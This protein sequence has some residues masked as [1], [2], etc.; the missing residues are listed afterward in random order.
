MGISPL[1]LLLLIR[2]QTPEP[3]KS[4]RL[5]NILMLLEDSNLHLFTSQPKNIERSETTLQVKVK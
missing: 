2:R 4:Q 5:K 3:T 1:L